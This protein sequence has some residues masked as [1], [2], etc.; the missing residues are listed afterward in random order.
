MD[1]NNFL[2]GGDDEEGDRD[3]P[4]TA[5]DVIKGNKNKQKQPKK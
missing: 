2:F 5:K 4:I 1:P 3:P